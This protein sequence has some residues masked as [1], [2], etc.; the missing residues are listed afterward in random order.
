MTW[1]TPPVFSDGNLLTAAQLNILSA[2]LLETAVAK[3]TTS[4]SYPVSTG[5]FTLAERHIGFDSIA[6]QV[7][8][9]NTSFS[10]LTASVGPTVTVTSGARCIGMHSAYVEH[11]SI[12]GTALSALD[13]S[14]ATTVSATDNLSLSLQAAAVGQHM[15]ASYVVV[16]Q[17]TSGSNTFQQKYRVSAGTGQFAF[18]RLT[19]VPY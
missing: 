12:G 14:G 5:A 17:M 16:Y 9:T 6:T 4:G 10:D 19:I 11:S 15:R 7:S 2:N 18:R 13:I 1:S 3:A 8:H